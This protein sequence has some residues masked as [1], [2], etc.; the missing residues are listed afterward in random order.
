MSTYSISFDDILLLILSYDHVEGAAHRERPSNCDYI[1]VEP[2]GLH[3][4]CYLIW[5]I[6]LLTDR[7]LVDLVP[8]TVNDLRA[9]H[10]TIG[11]NI[12]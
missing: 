6:V 4:H 5:I 8:R 10:L 11:L 12:D 1:L 9:S 2:G 3:L 7:L